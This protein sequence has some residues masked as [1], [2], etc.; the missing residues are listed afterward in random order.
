MCNAYD[1]GGKTGSFPS[2]MKARAVR[3]LEALLNRQLIR[4]TDQAPV[5]NAEGE[6][7]S[8]SWGFRRPKLGV[9]NN[10]RPDKL[11]GAIWSEPFQKRRCLIP[12]AGYYEWTGPKG[13]KRTFRFEN[14]EENW[15]WMAGLWEESSQF[16]PCF[17]MITTEANETVSPIHHR[18][19]ALLEGDELEEY[20]VGRVEDFNPK[21]ASLNLQEVAN[22]LLKNPATSIQE[23]LF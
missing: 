19:P 8:M 5:L 11:K 13:H 7:V 21:P 23:E 12:V 6:L 9:I 15:M 20:L 16:G 10:S 2:F 1:I 17:S 3:E 18:M 22:P 4:R 14:P